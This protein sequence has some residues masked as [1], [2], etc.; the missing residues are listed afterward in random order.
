M[1][2]KFNLKNFLTAYH[3]QINQTD[4][5]DQTDQINQK[6]EVTFYILHFPFSKNDRPDK[7]E[8]WIARPDPLFFLR[9]INFPSRHP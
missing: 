5:K 4:Q 3:Y 9:M 1:F 7:R 6:V 8:S 2:T